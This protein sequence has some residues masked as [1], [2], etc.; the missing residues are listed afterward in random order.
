MV[1]IDSDITKSEVVLE[2]PINVNQRQSTS[3]DVNSDVIDVKNDV[4]DVNKSLAERVL[5]LIANN[6]KISIAE[7][8]CAT[9]Q[10]CRVDVAPRDILGHPWNV[11]TFVG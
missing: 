11:R 6:L 1:S 3:D 10:S 2:L 4:N 8:A 5:T 7:P 9:E